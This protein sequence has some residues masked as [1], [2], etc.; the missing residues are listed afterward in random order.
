V[1]YAFRKIQ[2]LVGVLGVVNHPDQSGMESEILGVGMMIENKNIGCVTSPLRDQ[3]VRSG[4][5]TDILKEEEKDQKDA[6]TMT[7]ITSDQGTMEIVN[8][9]KEECDRYMFVLDFL[10]NVISLLTF[11]YFNIDTFN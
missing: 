4:M 9:M 3:E 6:D 1:K 2:T 5:M 8:A 7:W 10:Y 11:L